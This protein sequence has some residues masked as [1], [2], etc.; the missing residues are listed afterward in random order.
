MTE[1]PRVDTSRRIAFCPHCGNTTPQRLVFEQRYSES[2]YSLDGEDLGDENPAV[3]YVAVCETWSQILVYLSEIQPLPFP[4]FCLLW[5]KPPEPDRS[6]PEPIRECY[7][8][9][10]RIRALSPNGFAVLVRRTPEAICDDRGARKGTL[11]ELLA[12]LASK[13]E[14]PPVLAEMTTALRILGN[15]GAH[16]PSQSVRPGHVPAIDEFLVAVVEYVYVAPEKVKAFQ[17]VLARYGRQ[18]SPTESVLREGHKGRTRRSRGG[19]PASTDP[20]KA[21]E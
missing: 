8:E 15:V 19:S 6:V 12:N 11:H 2:G 18:R 16:S 5:P 7:R 9:A 4:D 10:A 20:T 14:I 1:P 3:Y 17:Q 21:A 13:N